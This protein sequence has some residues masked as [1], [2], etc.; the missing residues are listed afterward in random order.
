VLPPLQHLHGGGRDHDAYVP[1]LS[2][3]LRAPRGPGHGC[4]R[5]S[6][7]GGRREEAQASDAFTGDWRARAARASAGAVAAWGAPVGALRFGAGALVRWRG[8]WWLVGA[9]AVQLGASLRLAARGVYV[10][11]RGG[12]EEGAA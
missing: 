11:H 2:S 12:S 5:R 10:F 7:R 4:S 6:T 3:A 9:S 1:A 8:G